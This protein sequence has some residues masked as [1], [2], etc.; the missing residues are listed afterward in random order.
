MAAGLIVVCGAYFYHNLTTFGLLTPMQEAVQ[1]R[2][3]GKTLSDVLAAAQEMDLGDELVR[4]FYRRSLWTGGWSYLQ[5]PSAAV[6][7]QE[8]GFYFASLGFLFAL[9]PTIRKRRGLSVSS[10]LMLRV[11]L[12]CALTAAGLC[13]HMVHTKML[14]GSVATN[15]WYA[16]VIFPWFL[17]LYV[18]G[19]AYWPVP[20]IGVISAVI[21]IATFLATELRGTLMTMLSTYTGGGSGMVAIRRMAEMHPA[22]LGP[23]VG[24]VAL[25]GVLMA[26]G[27]AIG[28]T[29]TGSSRLD[30]VHEQDGHRAED[31]HRQ[32]RG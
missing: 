15:I 26:T 32:P 21:L 11:F 2:A 13:Y 8:Y 10:G 25:V 7:V 3:A 5:P 30:V 14:L 6:R 4:R 18:Q 9:A 16:A 31:D 29:M 17:V 24:G 23:I 28:A 20:R 27:L 22:W 1:N 12:L 19:L